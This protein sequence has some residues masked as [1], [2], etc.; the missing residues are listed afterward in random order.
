MRIVAD[1]E[2]GFPGKIE[3]DGKVV[4]G[5]YTFVAYVYGAG[6]V[7]PQGIDLTTIAE[8]RA[9]YWNPRRRALV[10]PRPGGR[11]DGY[12]FGDKLLSHVTDTTVVFVRPEFVIPGSFPKP[13][14]S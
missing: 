6:E 12:E 2:V 1:P 3:D 5:F 8:L 13:T 9:Q 7:P 4:D 11:P 14:V 10:I